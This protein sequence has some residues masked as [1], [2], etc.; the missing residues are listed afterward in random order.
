MAAPII[1]PVLGIN[2]SSAL[3]AGWYEPDGAIV[4]PGDRVVCL[5]AESAAV[6]VEADEGGVLRHRHEAGQLLTPGEVL[7]T[8]EAERERAPGS[9]RAAA[10]KDGREDGPRPSATAPRKAGGPEAT[11]LPAARANGAT[12]QRRSRGGPVVAVPLSMRTT[13][14][15]SEALAVS[16]QL[17]REWGDGTAHPRAEDIVLRAVARAIEETGRWKTR[18]VGLRRIDG[19][20]EAIHA[21]RRLARV[22]FRSGVEE[23]ARLVAGKAEPT[24][25]VICTLTSVADF[26]IEESTPRLGGS[27][28]CAFSLGAI[29]V[30]PEVAGDRVRGAPVATLTLAYD[31]AVVADGAAARM[32]ARVRDLVEAPYALLIA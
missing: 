19:E 24:G 23:L 28:A 8:I 30:S 13:V 9:S 2:V 6:D 25:P 32:L 31:A 20:E 16:K 18:A 22:P 17:A 10:S 7:G 1:V 11:G 5:E 3:L 12:P 26:G 21:V 27:Q 14:R 4:R 15:M 29:R